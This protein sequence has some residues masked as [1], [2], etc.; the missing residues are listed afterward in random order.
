MIRFCEDDALVV[1][2]M[3]IDDGYTIDELYQAK[4]SYRMVKKYRDD[5]GY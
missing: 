1:A 3:L 4:E 5:Y 2:K